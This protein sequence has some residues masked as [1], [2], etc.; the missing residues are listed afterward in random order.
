MVV[1]PAFTSATLDESV[2][3]S[4]GG[5]P[6]SFLFKIS[7]SLYCP[8][9]DISVH[10]GEKEVLFPAF[11]HFV[12]ESVLEDCDGYFVVQMKFVR[13]DDAPTSIQ[14]TASLP[15]DVADDGPIVIRMPQDYEGLQGV[16]HVLQENLSSLDPHMDLD[17]GCDSKNFWAQAWFSS[18]ELAT[19]AIKRFHHA[20]IGTFEVTAMQ[21]AVVMD[22]CPFRCLVHVTLTAVPHSGTCFVDLH[23][24]AAVLRL[25]PHGRSK[26]ALENGCTVFLQNRKDDL[27]NAAISGSLCVSKIPHSYDKEKLLVSFR[28]YFPHLKLSDISEFVRNKDLMRRED[29]TLLKAGV[30]GIAARTNFLALV[31]GSNVDY[32]QERGIKNGARFNLWYRSPEEAQAAAK[33][34]HGKVMGQTNLCAIASSSV[35]CD[36]LFPADIFAVVEPNL[37][38]LRQSLIELYAKTQ[39]LD[40]FSKTLKNGIKVC[41][42]SVD[43]R[44]VLDAYFQL[45][46]LQRG[47]IIS[48]S[49]SH[50]PKVFSPFQK[51]KVNKFLADLGKRYRV[52]IKLVR[53]ASCIHVIGREHEQLSAAAEIEHFLSTSIFDVVFGLPFKAIASIKKRVLE[54]FKGVSCVLMERQVIVSGIDV[55]A[56]HDVCCE[57]RALFPTRGDGQDCCICLCPSNKSLG[58]CGHALCSECGSNYVE[59]KITDRE[60]PITCPYLD[61]RAKLLAE[62]LFAMTGSMATLHDAAAKSFLMSHSS[63]YTNCHTLNCPQFLPKNGESVCCSLC[64]RTQCPMCGK[65]PH[66]GYSCEDAENVALRAAPAEEHRKKITEDILVHVSFLFNVSFRHSFAAMQTLKCQR[67][68]CGAAIFDFDGCFAVTCASC[69]CGFCAW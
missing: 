18:S 50:R 39:K 1:W 65:N 22:Q 35:D 30:H 46:G 28:R 57:L 8:L 37:I 2:A 11:S 23:D 17:V 31:G 64:L 36:I 4:F 43:A 66:A 52:F 53:D 13:P 3:K 10:P 16:T 49:A 7:T 9:M 51:D 26:F 6:G 5:G 14:M 47:K 55:A 63:Q 68:G 33:I 12:I 42:S 60:V 44:A 48:I 67:P 61:C 15:D 40:I 34:I 24:A 41:I 54:G 38:A 58:T 21:A 27:G 19:R 62:D 45:A 56:V 32:I 59:S 25:C 29:E 20:I 69:K